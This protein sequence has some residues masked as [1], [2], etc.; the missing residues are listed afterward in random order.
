MNT[1][2]SYLSSLWENEL[3]LTEFS[4]FKPKIPLKRIKNLK[5]IDK[6]GLK[7]DKTLIIGSAVLVLHG[8]IDKNHDLDLV[9][10]R[11]IF[12]KLSRIKGIKK[13]FKYN[14]VFYKTKKGEMEA[15]VNFQVMGKSTEELLKRALDIDGYKFMSL[16][17][18]YKM[19]KIL[20]RPKDTEKLKRLK[21]I[22]H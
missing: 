8:V 14:K 18:T 10:T 15:A 16:K 9:I 2:E 17:D 21:R 19:Y 3:P 7:K 6:L 20:N 13:D 11:P 4:L 12:N 1:I 5:L 22:F